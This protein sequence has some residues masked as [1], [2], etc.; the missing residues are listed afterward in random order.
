MTD[1]INNELSQAER[2]M[3]ENARFIFFQQL[4][5]EELPLY[6]PELAE[7]M[8]L[9]ARDYYSSTITKSAKKEIA[10]AALLVLQAEKREQRIGRELQESDEALTLAEKYGAELH[11]RER[12]LRE[13]LEL[14]RDSPFPERNPDG[15]E[16]WAAAVKLI[17]TEA[18]AASPGEPEGQTEP[19]RQ[20]E[21][22]PSA[23]L[24][25]QYGDAKPGSSQPMPSERRAEYKRRIR[26][27]TKGGGGPN[28]AKIFVRDSAQPEVL[29]ERSDASVE[30]SWV[31][32]YP[33][34]ARIRF[35]NEGE[36]R[37]SSSN[38]NTVVCEE[39]RRVWAWGSSQPD[40]GPGEPS[41]KR[42]DE[43]QIDDVI[44]AD[45]KIIGCGCSG[46]NVSLSAETLDGMWRSDRHFPADKMIPI[47]PAALQAGKSNG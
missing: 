17:A 4:A 24:A 22:L 39:T 16:Q 1:N 44:A 7:H 35:H 6:P 41:E 21:M 13:V 47:I 5:N 11:E 18:L 9:A 34:G 19:D 28:S 29:S 14:I 20:G 36:A 23:T 8:W 43:I 40:H 25:I 46:K 31:V 27:S 26:D 15:D 3:M 33:S 42:A 45:W 12:A 10:A 32:I 30:R 38:L 2:T 37:S